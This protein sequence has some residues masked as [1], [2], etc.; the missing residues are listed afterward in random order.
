MSR[1]EILLRGKKIIIER[2]GV[3]ENQITDNASFKDDL[4]ADSLDIVELVMELEDEFNIEIPD[5]KA[6]TFETVGDVANYIES[7][8]LE[9]V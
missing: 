6:E 3:D 5:E 7:K 4:G 8:L 1:D 2:L 9:S